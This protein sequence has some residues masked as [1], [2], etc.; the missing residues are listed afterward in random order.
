LFISNYQIE[1]HPSPSKLKTPKKKIETPTISS[2]VPSCEI[3]Q[4]SDPSSPSFEV[5]QDFSP[6][7]PALEVAQPYVS[8]V[9]CA[10]ETPQSPQYLIPQRPLSVQ[11]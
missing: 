2:I 6:S 5:A 10:Y 3:P 9:P 8:T 7:A 4:S 11:V 1:L